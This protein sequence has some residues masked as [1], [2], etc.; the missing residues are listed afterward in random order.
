MN[1]FGN[2]N[3]WTL[4]TIA[5]KDNGHLVIRDEILAEFC[6]VTYVSSFSSFIVLST[7]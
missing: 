4:N 3:Y 7:N 5:E 1:Y 6:A 2:W